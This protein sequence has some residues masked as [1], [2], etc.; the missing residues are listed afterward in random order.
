MAFTITAILLIIFIAIIFEYRI[1]KPDQIVLF[2]SG[3]VINARNTKIYPRHF[4]LAISGSIQS[5][6]IEFEVEAKGHLIVNIEIALTAAADKDCLENLIRTGGWNQNCINTA[7]AEEKTLLEANLKEYC[8]KFE[9]DELSSERLTDHLKK[10]FINESSDFGLK[11]VSI[12]TQSIEPKEKE[13][14]IALQQREEARLTEQTEQT[15]QKVRTNIAQTKVLADQKILQSEHE[16]E[17]KKLELK[18][19]REKLESD[20][21]QKRIQDELELK[22][23][24]LDFE[25]KEMELLQNNPELLMLS[26][27]LAR[28]AEASQQLPNAKTVV[29]LSPGELQQGSQIVETIQSV[30]QTIFNNKQVSS[31]HSKKKD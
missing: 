28:L 29:S 21:A 14:I 7:I 25:K 31:K 8:A 20:L 22:N 9:I 10:R 12:T 13:I 3:G 2:E 19:A 6:K 30:L 23:L 15:K 11:I 16:L 17:L 4:S 18:K 1:R 27:Q 26:P 24:Q 5:Q